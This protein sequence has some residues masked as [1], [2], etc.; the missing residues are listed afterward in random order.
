VPEGCG[1]G[2]KVH[3][4][5]SGGALY[6]MA[7][8]ENWNIRSRA[9][10][11]CHTA[12]PFADGETFM[13]V[14]LEDPKTGELVRRDYSLA[15]WAEVEP[16]LNSA[17]SFWRSE[18]EAVKTEARPEIAEKES[19]ETL[20]RRLCEEDSI[21]TENTRYILAVMLERKKQLKQTGTRE[22][23]DATFLVYEHQKSGEVYIIRDPELKLA[24]IEEVQTEVSRLLAGGNGTAETP[25]EAPVVDSGGDPVGEVSGETSGEGT[26]TDEE[27]ETVD[28]GLEEEE[29]GI[30]ESSE[31]GDEVAVDEVPEREISGEGVTSEELADREW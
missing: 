1:V 12:Q 26:V 30:G 17:F 5:G 19:A 10:A 2:Q 16:T 11:C 28:S 6:T 13:T 9:H 22:T 3:P 29:P 21:M 15:G 14:L 20:L 8:N 7:I 24:Q 4:A 18:Y 27:D 23:E 31:A 25:G